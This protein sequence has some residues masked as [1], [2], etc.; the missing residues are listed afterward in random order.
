LVAG[1]TGLVAGAVSVGLLVL[2]ADG[3]V[4][5][6]NAALVDIVGE[7]PN[8]EGTQGDPL[9]AA[10][11]AVADAGLPLSGLRPGDAPREVPWTGP[12]GVTRSLRL[13]CQALTAG[14]AGPPSGLTLFEVSDVTEVAI[15][16]AEVDEPRDRVDRLARVEELTRM[17]TW[18]WDLVT[19]EVAFSPN[20][21]A[22]VGFPP[23][24]QVRPDDVTALVPPDDLT[25]V[26]DAVSAAID[27]PGTFTFTH[28]LLLP[29]GS[30]ERTFE[31]SG[32]VVTDVLGLPVK[33][34]GTAQDVT[35]LHRVQREL[36]YL[37]ELDPLTGLYNRRAIVAELGH[38][39]GPNAAPQGSLLLIDADNFK[40]IN[41]V[42]GHAVGDTVLRALSEVLRD[43]L[44][45][46]VIGR[47][48]GDEFAVILPTGD[49]AEGMDAAETLCEEV[50]RRP[51]VIDGGAL[52]TTVSIGVVP[53]AATADGETA[54]ARA[55][56]ALSES[57]EAGRNRARLFAVEQYESAALRV[58]ASQRVRM[59]LDGGLMAV[60]AQP[61]VDLSSDEVIGY[62]LLARLRDGQQ[63][64]LAPTEFLAAVERTDLALRLDRWVVGQAVAA[65][66]ADG[67]DGNLYLHVNVSSRSLED[68]TFGDFV[69][70]ALGDAGIDPARLGLEITETAAITSMDA[71]RRLAEQLTTAGCRFILDDFGAG[72]GSVVHLRSLP[73][74]GIKIDGDFVRHADL[75]AEDTALVDALVRITRTL[76]MYSIA[77][78][79]DRESLDRVLRGLGVDYA[80]G[81]HHG[82]PRPLAELLGERAGAQG[83]RW[84]IG[85]GDAGDRDDDDAGGGVDGV[86]G[87]GDDDDDRGRMRARRGGA[88]WTTDAQTQPVGLNFR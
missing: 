9:F 88:E 71:A 61:L 11:L 30:G 74:S 68:P 64:E 37:A 44:P 80:Q 48:G 62:E 22:L 5:W 10:R 83:R 79:V 32:E 27:R 49:G 60:D 63:P 6:V 20:L 29:D 23:D 1:V 66:L 84:L 2:S 40:D 19:N 21:L 39:L 8:P 53:L 77:E 36:G 86:D 34:L 16:A 35:E 55:D 26:Q 42:R 41:D 56:L 81:Y 4:V 75:N 85:A 31:G 59:A 73:F 18:D 87:A 50:A 65:M 12:D 58:S 13:R 69:L 82:R 78:N 76:G 72:M 67:P 28:R 47:L 15:R 25:A 46:A 52:R 43:A 51:I 38:R 70:T 17:G 14:S 3:R 7:L 45:D 33:V 24:A 54:L 57:R